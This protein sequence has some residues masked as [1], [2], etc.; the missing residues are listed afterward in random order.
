LLAATV[1]L[2]V[3]LFSPTAFA[4]RV[5]IVRPAENDSVLVEAF[6][7]I[8]AELRLQDFDVATVDV[9]DDARSREVLEIVAQREGA[10]AS[11]VLVRSDGRIAVYI[12]LDDRMGGSPIVRRLEPTAGIELPSVLAIRVVDLLRVNLREFKGERPAPVMR[13]DRPALAETTAPAAHVAPVRPWEIRAE[14]IMIFNNSTL[15][16]AFGAGLGV[17]RHV[18]E[19]VRVGVLLTGPIV[20]ASWDAPEG[21]AF[22]RQAIGWGELRVSWFRSQWLECGASVAG[23]VHYLTAE[24]AP[25]PPLVSKSDQVWS[26]AGAL[27]VDGSFRFTSNAGV[28]LTLR[29]IG[30]TPRAGVGVGKST[31]VLQLPLLSASAGFVVDF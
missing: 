17:A 23:G 4:Q 1:A 20:G 30:L 10:L 7:R 21:S 9:A 31:T 26:A 19:S 2:G 22:V 11:V 15:G 5:A 13:I 27:G 6:N 3:V 29:A 14:G 12:W 8:T 28:S 18:A 16:P 24:S 25:K